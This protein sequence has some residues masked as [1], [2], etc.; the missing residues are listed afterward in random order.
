MLFGIRFFFFFYFENVSIEECW[1]A[2]FLPFASFHLSDTICK[3]WRSVSSRFSAEVVCHVIR[4][5]KKRKDN[6]AA[7]QKISLYLL[8]QKKH[9]SV[10]Y[11]STYDNFIIIYF[12]Y[13]SRSVDH[14]QR[15]VHNNKKNLLFRPWAAIID[16]PLSSFRLHSIN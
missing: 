14:H 2:L 7:S 15:M 9:I 1:S 16:Q 4:S 12:H 11:T 10:G 5:L 13:Q 8:V 6:N 3:C